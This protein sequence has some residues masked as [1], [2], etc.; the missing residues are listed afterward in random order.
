MP[1]C[2][3]HKSYWIWYLNDFYSNLM[4]TILIKIT[5]LGHSDQTDPHHLYE[6]IFS[7]ETSSGFDY[8]NVCRFEC[9]FED[10]DAFNWCSFTTHEHVKSCVTSFRPRMNRDVTLGQN[11]HSW[12][13]TVRLKVVQ[14]AMENSST[15]NNRR[16]SQS[17]FNDLSVVEVDGAPKINEEMV[18]RILIVSVLNKVV[19]TIRSSLPLIVIWLLNLTWLLIVIVERWN[20]F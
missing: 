12:D 9:L 2:L 14:V 10:R 3:A 13:S 5:L 11:E 7:L 4:R 18:S 6:S 17:V 1:L 19:L 15:W 8:I 16:F 20:V